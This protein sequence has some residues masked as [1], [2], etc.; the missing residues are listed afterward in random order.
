[1]QRSFIRNNYLIWYYRGFYFLASC[2]LNF[3][4][5]AMYSFLIITHLRQ[6]LL[7]S[8]PNYFKYFHTLKK[9]NPRLKSLI[10][11][12]LFSFVLLF[13][14]VHIL[15]FSHVFFLGLHFCWVHIFYLCFLFI[16]IGLVCHWIIITLLVGDTVKIALFRDI[17]II[18][19]L[20]TF[21]LRTFRR[22]VGQ[23]VTD[24]VCSFIL[25]RWSVCG[26][27]HDWPGVSRLVRTTLRVTLKLCGWV[28]YVID[29][30]FLY[31]IFMN[32]VAGMP[33]RV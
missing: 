11:L 10:L 26:V 21:V 27:L 12:I 5:M 9:I 16:S 14:L 30:E 13:Y 25:I 32:F 4:L 20:F 18:D 28:F 6:M 1:M 3:I 22:P 24:W 33:L 29:I 19:G 23:L 15:F 31:N 2:C 7:N 8:T 17:E